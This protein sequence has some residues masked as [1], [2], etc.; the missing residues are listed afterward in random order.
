[1]KI[2]IKNDVFDVVNRIKKIDKSCYILYNTNSK[3]YE[4]HSSRYENSYLF[5][6]GKNLDVRAVNMFQKALSS[7]INL[8]K[9]E[10]ENDEIKRKIMEKS[11][12]ENSYKIQ[13]II[14]YSN[15]KSIKVDNELFKNKWV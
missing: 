4:L 10:Q 6:L 9:I 3:R 11:K 1:M 2:E 13:K 5:S 8:E 7:K 12:D 14:D 15:K